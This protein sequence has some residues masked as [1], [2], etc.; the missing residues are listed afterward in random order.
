MRRTAAS[1]LAL[2]ALCSPV[3]AHHPIACDSQDRA[4][5]ST[6][7]SL[8]AALRAEIRDAGKAGCDPFGGLLS[9]P[10]CAER[11]IAIRD[12]AHR[13]EI[14]ELMS[15]TV[16]STC[17]AGLASGPIDSE[18]SAP[19]VSTAGRQPAPIGD[20]VEAVSPLSSTT[21]A[22][23]AEARPIPS[24]RLRVRQVGPVFLPEADMR[25][26]AIAKGEIVQSRPAS[27][28]T[29]EGSIESVDAGATA[30]GDR[31]RPSLTLVTASID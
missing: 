30:K 12:I 26:E 11:L 9:R 16:V 28:V 5:F 17:D 6:V 22:A 10:G 18:A 19:I 25:F 31:L 21:Q 14:A 2:A 1:L 3:A 7:A 29:A 20:G 13:I 27:P 23:V 15:E 8:E 24:S 4:G